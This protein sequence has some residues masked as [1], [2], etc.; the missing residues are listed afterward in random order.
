MNSLC[1]AFGRREDASFVVASRRQQYKEENF[2]S[3][4][5]ILP[6]RHTIR[7]YASS[8]VVKAA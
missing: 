7:R 6:V 3:A 4:Y 8:K 1:T 2:S 5:V